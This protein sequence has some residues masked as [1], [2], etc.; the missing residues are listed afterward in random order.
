MITLLLL[1]VCKLTTIFVCDR[2]LALFDIKTTLWKLILELSHVNAFDEGETLLKYYKP[3]Q[4]EHIGQTSSL[5]NWMTL[6][7]G[8]LACLG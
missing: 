6:N 4:N 3:S 7:Q 8:K 5:S 1:D 2:A